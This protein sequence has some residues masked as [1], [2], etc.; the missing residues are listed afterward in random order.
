MEDVPERKRKLMRFALLHLLCCD[1][2]Y[3]TNF[4]LKTFFQNQIG[5]IVLELKVKGLV[6]Q[7][8]AKDVQISRCVHRDKPIFRI[9]VSRSWK[10]S[11]FIV[12]T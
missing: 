8:R 10:L 4:K 2:T 3:L 11:D 5:K 7:V 12:A 9:Q 1:L 6:K